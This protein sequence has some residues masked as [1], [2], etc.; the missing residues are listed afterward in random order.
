MRGQPVAQEI[1]PDGE[2]IPPCTF[3]IRKQFNKEQPIEIRGQR[4]KKINL[5]GL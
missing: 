1:L 3:E 5:I 4:V 2:D